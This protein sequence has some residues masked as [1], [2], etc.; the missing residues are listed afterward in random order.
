[1]PLRR[2]PL[3]RLIAVVLAAA[4]LG[5]LLNG[6][7]RTR[8][9]APRPPDDAERGASLASVGSALTEVAGGLDA[10]WEI[11]FLP[12]GGV[13]VT[14]RGGRL[15]ALDGQGVRRWST[16]VPGVHARGEG[17][18]LGVALHPRFAET[19]W[20]YVYLTAEDENRVERYRL[21]PTGELAERHVILRGIPAAGFHDG[22]RIAFGRDGLL[23]ATT[24]D[25]GFRDGAQDPAHLGG[26][27]LRV[28]DDGAIPRDNPFGTA[29]YSLGHRNP[30]GLAWDDSGALWST[31]HG[32]SGVSSGLDEVNRIVPGGNYGWPDVQG[33]QRR[34]DVVP[35][36]LHSGPEH[37]WAPSGAAWAAG[38]LWFGGLRG[39]ALYELRPAPDGAAL[40]VH[41]FGEL[42]RVRNVREGPE[43]RLWILTNNTDGRGRPG[44][45]DDRLLRVD[46]RVLVQAR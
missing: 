11:A 36:V 16:P 15:V 17:G 10:P 29:V 9:F 27:I 21:G 26:K 28:S 38:R 33:D 24:G 3:P 23:Y 34:P 12:D 8:I 31:E 42:G 43:G 13:L 37:T 20:L 32:R 18:L 6:Y 22:G 7:L 41:F 35:P 39:Q 14:E 40:T 44:E 5:A 19:R 46:P 1:M 25:A 30:Q 4:A 45:G 2:P